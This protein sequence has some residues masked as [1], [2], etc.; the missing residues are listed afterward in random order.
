MSVVERG[1]ETHFVVKNGERHEIKSDAPA[2]FVT[3]KDMEFDGEKWTFENAV[4]TND[5]NGDHTITH[6]LFHILYMKYKLHPHLY[7]LKCLE[8]F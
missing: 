2:S 4:Y 5:N 7:F 1:G 6:E 3:K 8:I